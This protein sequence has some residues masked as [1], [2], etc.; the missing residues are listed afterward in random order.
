M[1]NK[2]PRRVIVDTDCGVDDAF[3]LFFLLASP[4]V[5]IV[6]IATTHGT[7]TVENVTRNVRAVLAMGGRP[8]I[9]VFSGAPRPIR[10]PQVSSPGTHGVNGLSDADLPPA[11]PSPAF[12]GAI[13]LYGQLLQADSAPTTVLTLGPKTNLALALAARPALAATIDQVVSMGGAMFVPGNKSPTAESNI[14]KDPE[15]AAMVLAADMNWTLIPLDIIT[16]LPLAASTL[17]SLDTGSPRGRFLTAITQTYLTFHRESAGV[18]GINLTDPSA[19]AYLIRPDLFHTSDLYLEIDTTD[20]F[21]AGM[22]VAHATRPLGRG[23]RARV[24]LTAEWDAVHDL[25]VGRLRT[26]LG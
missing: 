23:H 6:G 22:T 25:I 8:D 1:T 11:E 21:T 10:R 18:D 13:D 15:A 5:D 3:A 12:P 26:I 17:A 19:A 16:R 14:L 24:A 9:P 4:E 20:G 7:T 2:T